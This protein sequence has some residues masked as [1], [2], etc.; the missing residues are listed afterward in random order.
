MLSDG[1]L[2]LVLRPLTIRDMLVEYA[3]D[4]KLTGGAFVRATVRNVLAYFPFG[5]I[6]IALWYWTLFLH[7]DHLVRD[8]MGVPWQ[9]SQ[10]TLSALPLLDF[11][12]VTCLAPNA[13]RT[14]C[15]YFVSS[16]IHYYGDVEPR[17]VIQQTQI[18]TSPWMIPF[19][20]FCFNFGSTH[21]IHHFAV[22]Y[23]FYWRQL[24]AG[25]SHRA[26][27]A[28]G[29]RFNDFASMRRGNNWHSSSSAK[30]A[31]NVSSAGAVGGV[32]AAWPQAANDA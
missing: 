6:F 10:F 4:H 13:L 19:Q 28:H 15:L 2:A 32:E 17:N 12:A 16:N 31:N 7:A 14:A 29:V 27:R 22:Q 18:W 8:M 3:G 25:E 9:P 5:P 21:A 1:L 20:L 30:P 11:L 23:P 24:V 26:M